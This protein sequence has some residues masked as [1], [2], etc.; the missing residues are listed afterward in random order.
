MNW[1][2]GQEDHPDRTLR[3]KTMENKRWRII[4]IIMKGCNM[5]EIGIPKGEES[6]NAAGKT[7][8]R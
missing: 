4:W 6:V 8:K 7:F 2:I 5:P 3:D 1:K